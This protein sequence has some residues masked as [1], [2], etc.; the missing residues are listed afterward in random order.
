[1]IEAKQIHCG[2]YK[3]YGDFFRV[4]NVQTDLSKSEAIKWCFDN[5]YKRVVPPTGEWHAKIRY[6]GPKFSDADYYFS[7][8][9]SIEE[10]EGGFTFSICEPFA[11]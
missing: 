4:W 6:G 7:G 3:P 8:Y 10:I 1:M 5:L 11:D 2:Q 9:Y